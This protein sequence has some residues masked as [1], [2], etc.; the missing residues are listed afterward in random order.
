M[1]SLREIHPGFQP[2]VSFALARQVPAYEELPPVLKPTA[3]GPI[4]P[5]MHYGYLITFEQFFAIAAMQLGFSIELKD[6]AWSEDIAMHKVAQY[7]AGKVIHHPT[8][9][10][11]VCVDR[12]R[13][14]LLSLCTN[15]YP[16][17]RLEEVDPKV[18]E[19]LG[20]EEKGKWYLDAKQWQWRA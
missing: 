18:R 16:S 2:G 7:I 3:F 19:Y 14:F 10:A 9:V 5:I 8:K 12:K 6:H 17:Q 4:P 20:I 11:W 1:S 15:W 13:P